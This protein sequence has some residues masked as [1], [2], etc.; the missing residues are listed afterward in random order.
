MVVLSSIFHETIA[1]TVNRVSVF[2]YQAVCSLTPF[3]K[4]SNLIASF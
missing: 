3:V 4:C 1:A 2:S